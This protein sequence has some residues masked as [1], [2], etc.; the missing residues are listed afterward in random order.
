M[1]ADKILRSEISRLKILSVNFKIQP[2]R[3]KFNPASALNLA[4]HLK[5]SRA[6]ILNFIGS[7]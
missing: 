5:F 6:L 3:L 4:T 1:I 7:P 2:R